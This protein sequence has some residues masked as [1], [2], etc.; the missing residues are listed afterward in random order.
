MARGRICF[1]VVGVAVAATALG[2]P[3][4]AAGR[5]GP[6]LKLALP[7]PGHITI[8]STSVT[9]RRAG[10]GR[11]PTRMRLRA[12]RPRGLPRSVRVLWATRVI[13]RKRTVTYATLLLAINKAR[14]Q[15]TSAQA[16]DEPPDPYELFVF[17]LNGGVDPDE[18]KVIN[19]PSHEA[20]V[21]AAN[22]PA[23]RLRDLFDAVRKNW[24]DGRI[25][26]F[27]PRPQP[28]VEPFIDTG[29][30]DDGHAFG[31]NPARQ[32]DAWNALTTSLAGREAMDEVVAQVE[33]NLGVDI[34]ADGDNGAPKCV[35]GS[36]ESPPQQITVPPTGRTD[37]V[38][39]DTPIPN[40][41]YY[42][43]RH[44]YADGGCDRQHGK[45]LAKVEVLGGGN[46]VA[47][48]DDNEPQGEQARSGEYC[49]IPDSSP[50]GVSNRCLIFRPELSFNTTDATKARTYSVLVGFQ[51][52]FADAGGTKHEIS[53][54]VTWRPN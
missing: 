51:N 46:V 41:L 22:V 5:A 17:F 7:S 33:N 3:A 42:D 16:D 44:N 31:W 8:D 23:A 45:M 54:R 37:T 25:S 48:Y 35:A 10:R 14:R 28:D 13:P 18:F 53:M 20:A 11:L 38:W 4:G 39:F 34:D 1:A 24:R 21:N 50:D 15:A 30:Y 19:K 43:G 2:A 32:L 52:E 47:S 12:V 27:D 40:S 29:H 26:V 9:V 49:P 36:Y 6:R